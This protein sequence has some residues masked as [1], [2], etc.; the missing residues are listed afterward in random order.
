MRCSAVYGFRWTPFRLHSSFGTSVLD[1]ADLVARVKHH[2]RKGGDSVLSLL[3]RT[4]SAVSNWKLNKW[5]FRVPP[6]LSAYEKERWTLQLNLLKSFFIERGKVLADIKRDIDIISSVGDIPSDEVLSK[7]STWVFEKVSQLRWNGDVDK[8]KVLRDAFSRL[9]V[10]G[11]RDHRI[12]ERLCAVYGLGVMNSFEDAFD[13]V[14]IED[15]RTGM[16]TMM[17]DNFFRELLAVL[18]TEYPYISVLYDFLGFNA[19]TGYR[20]SLGMFLKKGAEYKHKLRQH[21]N[22]RMLLNDVQKRVILFD[23][24]ESKSLIASDDSIYGLPDFLYICGSKFF[25]ITVA[26]DNY[27]LRNRQLPHRKQMEGVGRRGSF[28]LGIPFSDVRI[29]N[30]LLPPNFVDKASLTR[31][32][33]N[34]LELSASESLSIFPWLNLYDKELDESDIDFCEM[35][36]CNAH[37]EWVTL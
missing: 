37:E 33:E 5:E 7:N 20:S 22:G 10:Y 11:A 12:L 27:W 31:L 36:K 17:K 9:G 1:H 15:Q 14:I 21:E 30:V 34:V 6:L 32:L 18:V 28:V 23:V 26:S 24:I 2:P 19:N 4:E 16:R 13:N 29:K 25:L 8:A 3:E 35:M